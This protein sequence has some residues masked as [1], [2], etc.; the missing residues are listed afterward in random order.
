MASVF[1]ASSAAFRKAIANPL[2]RLIRSGDTVAQDQEGNADRDAIEAIIEA[3]IIPQLVAAHTHRE[4]SVQL[5]SGTIIEPQDVKRFARL[6]LSEDASV[7]LREVD[8]QLA[9]G[10]SVEA[11][12]LDLLAPSARLL[13]RLWE[14]DECDFVAVTMGLWRLQEVMREMAARTPLSLVGGAAGPTVLFASMPGD[15]HTF[16]TIMIEELFSREGW[17]TELLLQPQRRELLDRLAHRSFNL[18]GLTISR[19]CPSAAIS[20]LISAIRNVSANPSIKIMIGGRMINENPHIVEHVGADAMAFDAREALSVAD[21]L[22]EAQQT[23]Q[24][25]V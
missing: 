12:Y 17:N 20:Q 13:G 14:E 4:R 6:P 9:K 5:T 7:L 24:N 16:G 10:V 11:I 21:C 18:V 1:G 25:G 23:A 22:V 8:K 2:A 3:E 19:D 15:Q